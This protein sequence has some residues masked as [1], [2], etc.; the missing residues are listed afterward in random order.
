MDVPRQSLSRTQ[1]I[2]GTMTVMARAS[3]CKRLESRYNGAI[4]KLQATKLKRSELP[5]EATSQSIG[6]ASRASY[7]YA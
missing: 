7:P 4:M 6:S 5:L 1:A 2:E 3:K